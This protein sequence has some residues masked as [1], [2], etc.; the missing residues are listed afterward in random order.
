LP[1][2]EIF[3]KYRN[4]INYYIETKN[5]S[6]A[7]RRNFISRLRYWRYHHVNPDFITKVKQEN[8]KIHVNSTVKIKTEMSKQIGMKVNG[9]LR[10]IQSYWKM[11]NVLLNK[12]CFRIT[13]YRYI[14]PYLACHRGIFSFTIQRY[15]CW[16][17]RFTYAFSTNSNKVYKKILNKWIMKFIV[18]RDI[19]TGRGGFFI[20]SAGSRALYF[21]S[22]LKKS[23]LQARF[24]CLH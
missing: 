16:I 24:S 11:K 2:D 19:R 18:K 15:L 6:K 8:L 4:K 7:I 5:S 1:L 10:G 21:S 9:I 17:Y 12:G 22:S 23:T 3:E 13:S 14:N 20:P